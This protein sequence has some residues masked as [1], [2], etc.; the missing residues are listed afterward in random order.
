MSSSY[1]SLDVQSDLLPSGSS[2]NNLNASLAR[3]LHATCHLPHALHTL[4]SM[5]C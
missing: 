1:I 4:P 2:T 5:T 3:P